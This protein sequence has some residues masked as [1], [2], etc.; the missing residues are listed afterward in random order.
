M[1]KNIFGFLTVFVCLALGLAAP[2]AAK[3]VDRVVAVVNGEII[4]LSEI[5]T[6]AEI[7]VKQG[8]APLAASKDEM[9][10][11]LLEDAIETKL[12]LQEAKRLDLELSAPELTAAI[13]RIVAQNR[14]DEEEFRIKLEETGI[15]YAVFEEN[16]RAQLTKMRLVNKEV[17]SKVMA[18][19]EEVRAYYDEHRDKYQVENKVHLRQVVL[20]GGLEA[21]QAQA[22]AVREK[23][24]AG[25]SFLDAATEAAASSPD[26]YSGD[27]GLVSIGDLAPAILKAI[28]GL[29]PRQ[30]SE[31]IVLGDT[32]QLIQVVRWYRTGDIITD[33]A[34][35]A[36]QEILIQ[37]KLEEAFDR[38]MDDLRKRSSVEIRM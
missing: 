28:E 7:M 26:T 32:V 23:V 20:D 3:V 12:M 33:Q 30:V 6:M 14:M 5:E 22:Q 4:T 27:M 36:I 37:K 18:T 16:V 25:G 1:Q 8:G 2:A 9:L 29:E 35:Q 10:G 21:A 11:K 24:M 13:A 15:P 34:R 19:E 31:P 38:W 17:R